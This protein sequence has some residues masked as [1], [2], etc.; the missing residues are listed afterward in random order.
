MYAWR[1]SESTFRLDLLIGFF[2]E[3]FN[4]Y[5]SWI[6]IY[7]D[8]DNVYVYFFL[9]CRGE[10]TREHISWSIY[11]NSSMKVLWVQKKAFKLWKKIGKWC[12]P[13]IE[14][15]V[16]SQDNVIRFFPFLLL[17]PILRPYFFRKYISYSLFLYSSYIPFGHRVI[18]LMLSFLV[19]GIVYYK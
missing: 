15:V 19:P 8:I 11:L 9:I 3:S 17:P 4:K 13:V 14:C 12:I 7:S 5:T 18:G 1:I 16:K 10:R 2:S 6:W